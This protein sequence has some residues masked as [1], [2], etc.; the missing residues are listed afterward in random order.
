MKKYCILLILLFFS[1]QKIFAD[2]TKGGWM[3]YEYLGAGSAPNTLQ[4]RIVLKTYTACTLSSGQFNPT[5]N[6]TIFNAGNNQQLYN[7][8]VTNSEITDIQNCTSQNCHPCINPIPSICYKIITYE[9]VQDLPISANGYT[10]AYQRCCRIAGIINIQNPSNSVGETWTVK[11]PGTATSGAELNSSA[12]FSQNDTAIICQSNAFVFDFSATDVNDDSLVYSFVPAYAGGNNGTNSAPNAASAPPFALVPYAAGFSGIQPMGAGVTINPQTGMVTG[13]APA[14]GIY[15]ITALVS[16]YR[17]GTNIKIAEVRKSLHIAVENCNTTSAELLPDYTS[18]DGFTVNFKNLGQNNNIQ[19]FYWD[20][21]DGTSSGL[22]FPIHTY[23]DTGIYTLKLVVN[24]GLPCADSITAP[25]KVFPGFFPDYTVQ[26]QCKN[27]AIQFND[28]TTAT[29]GA[30]NTWKWN[31]GDAT[32]STNTSVIKSPAHTYATAGSYEVTLIVTSNKG[33]IDTV[34]KSIEILD[35]P[36]FTLTND[37]LI[38]SID[39]LQLNAVG[40]GSFFWSP[41]YMISNVNS[42]SPLVSPD[43]TTTYYVTITDPFGCVG[44]D[45]VKVRVVDF[46]TQFAPN[47]TTICRT[48]GVVL[49]L[50]SDALYYTWTENPAGNTLSNPSIKNPVATPLTNTTYNVVG[51]IGKCVAQSDIFIKTVPYP[52]A[53]AGADQTICFGTS[54]QLNASG[55]SSYSWTPTAFLNNRLIPNPQSINPTANVRYIV[56]VTDTLGC[57]KPVRDTMVL[58]VAKIKA[59]AG[60]RDTSVVLGQPLLLQAT[61]STNYLWSPAQWLTNIGIANPV[62]LPQDDINYIVKVSNDVG[63]FDYDTIRVHLFKLDAG[64]YVPSGFS[65]NGDGN[66]DVFRPVIL[67]MKSL[68]LFRVYNRWGQLLYSGTDAQQGWDGTFGGKGQEA[69][70]YVWYAEGTDYKNNK[71]KKKGYVVLIR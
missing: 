64:L 55:G 51:S 8:A 56:T 53:D 49:N 26:G 34:L 33:C 38:C 20:F 70:T 7:I 63:C 5:V 27:T 39:T 47:D 30:P 52:D 61:G 3:Y 60:P 9:L 24:R 1:F 32:S 68:D 50:V 16:E 37:T 31:F 2:H 65:P 69:A 66:N 14:S 40:T 15:V 71:I 29:Y 58:F 11:I 36:S 22:E 54:A 48:D 13:M 21:G 62:S 43:V 42:S 41:N 28:I 35:K 23:T 6:F 67:G 57:P 19:T 18:C 4:Y 46:V 25:V 12:K 10:V 44:G 59:D 45:S 17:R